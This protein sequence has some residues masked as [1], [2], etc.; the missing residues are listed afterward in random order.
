MPNKGCEQDGPYLP[1]LNSGH[2]DR[3]MI[4]CDVAQCERTQCALPRSSYY[5]ARQ[6]QLSAKS[7]STPKHS[8]AGGRSSL[9]Y[10]DASFLPDHHPSIR[11]KIHL[12]RY[13]QVQVRLC[14]FAGSG[15]EVSA[16]SHRP[17]YDRST[18][19]PSGTT[20]AP[21]S[22]AVRSAAVVHRDRRRTEACPRERGDDPLAGSIPHLPCSWPLAGH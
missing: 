22:A 4:G 8:N 20:P 12:E 15:T 3:L 6:P 18:A 21:T 1:W 13:L 14:I 11:Q 5:R 17:S 9:R 19:R 10:S 2:L 7:R 16:L